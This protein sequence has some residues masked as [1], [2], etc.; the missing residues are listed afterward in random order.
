[1]YADEMVIFSDTIKGLQ[2]ML[3]TL[4]CYTEKWKLCANINK[5]KI[6]VFRKGGIVK[7]NE[8]WFYNDVQV[9]VV[10]KFTYLGV[11]LNFYRKFSV[12][13]KNVAQQGGKA[14]FALFR[15]I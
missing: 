1:M 7:E 5:T 14:M 11:I 12:A 13:Q 8:K 6:A 15:N 4:Y 2:D 10:D 9:D 3:S